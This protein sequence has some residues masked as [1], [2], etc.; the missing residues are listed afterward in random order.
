MESKHARIA[1]RPPAIV[2]AA[3]AAF[4]V[5]CASA[6]AKSD[7]V[8]SASVVADRDESI[9]AEIGAVRD[10][11]KT[12]V[13]YY[14]SG[15][16]SER[17]AADLAV[18]FGAEIERIVERKPRNWTFMNGGAAAM[19]GSTPKIEEP[20][21][22]PADYERVF[23]LTPVWAWRLSPPVKTWLKAHRGELPEAGF[24]TI[25]GDTEPEKIVAKM[26]KVSG[27]E[28]FAYAGFSR[29]DFEPENRAVYV[30]KLRY[31]AGLTPRRQSDDRLGD[32]VP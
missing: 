29:R 6:G 2:L 16:A 11:K 32:R 4:A 22:N 26:A 24:G 7:A 30:Q 9:P 3:A 17:V 18:I 31:L 25:S 28:P 14:T 19:F 20:K 8:S 27:R 23:V 5:S 15:N 12:L 13:V 10:G 1:R 21:H